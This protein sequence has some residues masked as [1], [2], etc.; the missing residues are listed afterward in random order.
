MSFAAACNDHDLFELHASRFRE[1][2]DPQI[3]KLL[4]Q[5][6]RAFR[7]SRLRNHEQQNASSLEPAIGV[8]QKDGF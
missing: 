7:Q 4:A 2:E 8:F 1:P 3:D 5:Q 6:P